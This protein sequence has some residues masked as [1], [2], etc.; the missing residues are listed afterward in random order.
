MASNSEDNQ[1]SFAPPGSRSSLARLARL[2]RKELAEIL[3]DRRTVVTL[4]LMPLLVYPL[5]SVVFQQF[6]VVGQAGKPKAVEYQIGLGTPA[7]EQVFREL[8][9]LGE[10][11]LA[12]HAKDKNDEPTQ[13]IHWQLVLTSDLDAALKDGGI[14]LG[15]LLPEA[16]G[17]VQRPRR[18]WLARCEL[19]YLGGQAEAAAAMQFVERRLAAG[20]SFMLESRLLPPDF[21]GG[22]PPVRALRIIHAPMAAVGGDRL[23]S[24]AALV[25]L[26]LILMTIT[27]AVYP[28]IDLT[29]GERER[30][31]LEI[32]VAAPVPR[33]GLLLAK[34]VCVVTVAILTGLVN[35]TSMIIT[36]Q[37]VP[38][39]LF[40]D[41]GLTPLI[42]IQVFGLLVLFATF[43]AA[44]LLGLTSSARSF[45]EAQ[46]YLIPLMLLS[47]GP[48]LIGMLPG[49]MLADWAAAPLL[50]IVLLSRDLLEG[51]ADLTPSLVVIVT[52]LLYALAA[53][54]LAARIFG[55]ESVLYSD[56][57]NWADLWRRP[58]DPHRTSTIPGTLWC[59]AL[60]IPMQFLVQG[61]ANAL[62][63]LSPSGQMGLL[64]ALAF[65]LFV[66]WPAFI[67]HRGHVQWRSGFG[68]VPPRLIVWPGALLLGVSTWP[69]VLEGM[70]LLRGA[71]LEELRQ[72]LEAAGRSLDQTDL[73]LRGIMALSLVIQ[74]ACEEWFF[75]G[76]LFRSLQERCGPWLTIGSTALLFGLTHVVLG[77]ALGLERM[78][79]STALGLILGWVAWTSGSLWPGMV[80]HG[81][82]NAMLVLVA[83]EQTTIPPIWIGAGAIGVFV[84]IGLI[85]AGRKTFPFSVP[86]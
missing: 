31:T 13:P 84:G 2:A 47:L 66:V 26:I 32:L 60:M 20:Q 68:L 64:A 7:E 75:R 27:G 85:W 78:L 49:L 50:N 74:A 72:Q 34:Y 62:G 38:L 41:Q 67:A 15:V 22:P 56:Q 36:L 10:K 28:A 43:F 21:R 12:R 6:L 59:L 3:R 55:S 51:G 16:Q 80:M 53:I 81:L 52:T 65:M 57:G 18:D 86:R 11:A 44:V 45:K 73:A 61:L 9:T 1:T 71:R 48:G 76:L 46:A 4:V 63:G 14:D 69:L 82:H 39:D 58:A 8:M 54:A 79:P 42:V 5:L 37:V 40:G 33:L 23:I 17:I 70:A 29:A 25:P 35:L 19:R 24:L 77:G 30:G 83:N